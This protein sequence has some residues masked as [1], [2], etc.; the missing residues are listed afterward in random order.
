MAANKLS[1]KDVINQTLAAGL[2]ATEDKKCS[3]KVEP[4]S[5]GYMPGINPD[6]L[7]QVLDE[8]DVEAFAEKYGR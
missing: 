8:L 1:L 6:K 5:S 7:N 2:E 4:F 3:F